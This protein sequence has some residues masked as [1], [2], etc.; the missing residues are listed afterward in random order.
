MKE[1]FEG[2]GQN[3]PILFGAFVYENRSILTVGNIC[4][5]VAN[6][7]TVYKTILNSDPLEDHEALLN[8]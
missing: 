6:D 2:A 1:L 7:I 8:T 5:Q 4:K 3:S